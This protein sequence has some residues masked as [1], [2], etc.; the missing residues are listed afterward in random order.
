MAQTSRLEDDRL[1]RLALEQARACLQHGDVPV[2]AVVARDGEVLAVAGNARERLGDP[3]AHAEM[4]AL[5][6]AAARMGSWRLEGCT[7]VVTLEPCAMCAGAVVLARIE[8]V[9]FGAADPKAGF[10]GSLGDLVRD[11]RLNHRAAVTPGVLADECG[12]VLRAFFRERR[13]CDRSSAPGQ[14]SG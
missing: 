8:R 11:P 9:V 13:G 12:E 3:T 1:M 2:G 6:E 14:S 4:L 7:L 5:R 10:V